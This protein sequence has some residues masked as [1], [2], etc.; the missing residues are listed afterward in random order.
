MEAD[1]IALIICGA[2][3]LAVL[4]PLLI[5]AS[6]RRQNTSQQIELLKRAASRSRQPWINEDK[7]LQELSRLVSNLQEQG[8]EPSAEN[9]KNP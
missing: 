2:I 1:R 9:K 5:Y 3:G 6:L 8:K 7:S 4:I